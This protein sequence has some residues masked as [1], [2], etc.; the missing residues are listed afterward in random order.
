MCVCVCVCVQV[1]EDLRRELEHLQLFK[2]ETE[3][4]GRGRSSSSSLSDITYRTRE[5][6]LEHEVKRL[7]QVQHNTRCTQQYGYCIYMVTMALKPLT[8]GF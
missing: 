4:G 8:G 5:M 6:E 1:I 7:K 2:L 3:K